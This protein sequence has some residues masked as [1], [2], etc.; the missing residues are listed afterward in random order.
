MSA[1]TAA[2]GTP[3]EA[4]AWDEGE[5]HPSAQHSA[6]TGSCYPHTTCNPHTDPALRAAFDAGC[7]SEESYL[8]TWGQFNPHGHL[9]NPFRYPPKPLYTETEAAVILS[10]HRSGRGTRKIAEI[11]GLKRTIVTRVIR[12]A[13]L[14]NEVEK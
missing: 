13:V 3:A 14:K 6:G 5:Q 9:D 4:D 10:L 2:V 1:L 11:V 12:L 8:F 7:R